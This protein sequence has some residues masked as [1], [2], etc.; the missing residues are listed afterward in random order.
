MLKEGFLVGSANVVNLDEEIKGAPIIL[1]N[2]EIQPTRVMSNSF[3]FGGTNVS[4]IF[5]KFI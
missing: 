5:Q 1:K 4:L 2:E 3:G